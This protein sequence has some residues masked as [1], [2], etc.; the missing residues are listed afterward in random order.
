MTWG[1]KKNLRKWLAMETQGSWDTQN[2]EVC[3]WITEVLWKNTA[4]N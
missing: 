3:A 1:G 2:V 4:R